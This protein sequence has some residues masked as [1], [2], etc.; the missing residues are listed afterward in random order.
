MLVR[1]LLLRQ[2]PAAAER[3]LDAC[4]AALRAAPSIAAAQALVALSARRV[5]EARRTLRELRT[6]WPPWRGLLNLEALTA[7]V[8][9][10]R[11]ALE[12][13]YVERCALLGRRPLIGL[14]RAWARVPFATV[15]GYA[16]W[17]IALA[18]GWSWSVVAA[19]LLL[20]LEVVEGHVMDWRPCLRVGSLL[21]PVLLV[22]ATAFLPPGERTLIGSGVAALAAGAYGVLMR[23]RARLRR[24]QG[25]ADTGA[26]GVLDGPR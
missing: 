3:V 2:D 1:A 22:G 17:G 20:V 16:A 23:Y 8:L 21:A 25:T 13:A 26:A 11:R 15:L 14:L 5:G 10:D 6:R 18:L 7:W 4:P 12:E 19:F 9:G 24:A